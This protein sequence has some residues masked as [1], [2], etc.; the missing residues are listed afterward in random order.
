MLVMV[1]VA[2]PLRLFLRGF[3]FVLGR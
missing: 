3:W 2:E 1:L